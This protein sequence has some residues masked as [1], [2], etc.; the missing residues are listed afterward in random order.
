[1]R[2]RRQLLN[3]RGHRCE[4]C[5]KPG[6]LEVHHVVPLHQGGERF[7]PNNCVVL[8]VPHHRARHDTRTPA[9]REWDDFVQE[10]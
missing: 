7:D 5:G 4:E 9:Q 10:G 8:C 2:F 6:K 3:E 1:M